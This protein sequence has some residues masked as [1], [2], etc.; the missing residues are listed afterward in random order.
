MEKETQ[1]VRLSNLFQT[2][3][4]LRHIIQ[5]LYLNQESEILY[6]FIIFLIW[7]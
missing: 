2:K 1:V 7:M 4:Q 5:Y 6:F 3:Q